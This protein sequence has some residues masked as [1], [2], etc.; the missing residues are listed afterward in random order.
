MGT[1][2]RDIVLYL[3]FLIF[4]LIILEAIFS[5]GE[6]VKT[7]LFL[8][9]MINLGLI[10][11]YYFNSTP[12][13]KKASKKAGF[14]ILVLLPI[15]LR[16]AD[17]LVRLSGQDL[18]AKRNA[19]EVHLDIP[20]S[21]YELSKILELMDH[22]LRLLSK[23]H[24]GDLILWETHVPLPNYIRQIIRTEIQKGNAFWKKGSFPIPKPPFVYKKLD[25][26]RSRY[27]AGIVPNKGEI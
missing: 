10:I 4:I 5:W 6:G 20:K 2:G 15:S 17:F 11:N 27:G 18:S 8:L 16:W 9:F 3:Y 13:A 1:K 22:D 26:K 23:N 12:R 14:K 25:K 19:Y 21:K 7:L 24:Q